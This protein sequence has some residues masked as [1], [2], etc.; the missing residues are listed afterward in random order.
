MS[1]HYQVKLAHHIITHWIQMDDIRGVGTTY[2]GVVTVND[3]VLAHNTREKN[4]KLL[5][6]TAAKK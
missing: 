1:Y 6:A 2:K 5:I 4:A 3:V